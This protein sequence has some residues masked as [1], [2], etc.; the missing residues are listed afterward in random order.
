MFACLT[1]YHSY[2]FHLLA[3]LLSSIL[4][5]PVWA[6]SIYLPGCV[7]PFE[8]F[9]YK[10]R[11]CVQL[12]SICKSENVRILVDIMCMSTSV[13]CTCTFWHGPNGSILTNIFLNIYCLNCWFDTY[14]SVFAQAF[15]PVFLPP[16]KHYRYIILMYYFHF[17]LSVLV[18]AC[19]LSAHWN[20]S[21]NCHTV[22]CLSCTF[23]MFNVY[24]FAVMAI[25]Y[26]S[27]YP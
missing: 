19:F 5:C 7:H 18:L 23:P 3:F 20:S 4:C 11:N 24:S 10:H 9:I 14:M 22:W 6:V 26:P 8:A 27:R 13:R 25:L 21:I 15:V 16:F 12:N 17:L 2:Q 1:A